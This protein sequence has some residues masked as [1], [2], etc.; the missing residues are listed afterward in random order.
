[1]VH[2]FQE[3]RRIGGVEVGRLGRVHGGAAAH[4]DEGVESAFR[5]EIDGL[6]KRR[7][8][9]LDADR[10]EKRELHVLAGEGIQGRLDGRALR[11][12]RVREHH[13]PPDAE[14][15]QVH[16]HFP[17][18]PAPEADVGRR[19]LEREVPLHE[20]CLPRRFKRSAR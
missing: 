9:R 1:M 16:P 10:I 20:A 12:V 7:V 13:H 18:D 4:G 2:V 19:H 14:I 8:G 15:G 3:V 5:R 6:L 11:Q 17:G